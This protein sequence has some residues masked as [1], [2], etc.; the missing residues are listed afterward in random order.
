MISP[1]SSSS[2][3]ITTILI[4]MNR[5]LAQLLTAPMA[6]GMLFLMPA[7]TAQTSAYNQDG[8]SSH[9]IAPIIRETLEN[10][11]RPSPGLLKSLAVTGESESQ[12][13]HFEVFQGFL[14]LFGSLSGFALTYFLLLRETK[15]KVENI[16][17][18]I[19]KL[20]QEGIGNLKTDLINKTNSLESTIKTVSTELQS[21]V[22]GVNNAVEKIQE[23]IPEINKAYEQIDSKMDSKIIK[24]NADFD[25][26]A[27]TIKTKIVEVDSK[28]SNRIIDL[29]ETFKNSL[30][31][32]HEKLEI[33]ITK[34]KSVTQ[35]LSNDQMPELR[36]A[37][38]GIEINVKDIEIDMN[39]IKNR[40]GTLDV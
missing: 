5:S 31:I 30:D 8:N 25:L 9:L 14:S 24:F 3:P 11:L 1:S 22:K 10:P 23:F 28:I 2:F 18:E 37:V 12:W 33:Q 17:K 16:E 27:A 35:R 20:N 32:N 7:G 15:A 38:K 21:Q 19:A 6:A 13:T 26:L 39:S 29:K 40:L 36:K 4:P 34:L